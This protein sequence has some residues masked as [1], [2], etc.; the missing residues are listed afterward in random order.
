MSN[1]LEQTTRFELATASLENWNST[2]EVRLH[3][4]NKVIYSFKLTEVVQYFLHLS[5]SLRTCSSISLPYCKLEAET[6]VEPV[7]E[8]LQSSA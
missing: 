5:I 7:L 3:E 6:G 1:K 4:L 8:D 2:I